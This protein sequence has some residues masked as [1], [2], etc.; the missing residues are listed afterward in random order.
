MNTY[1]TARN[2]AAKEQQTLTRID[3]VYEL[4]Q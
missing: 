1:R 3:Y 4:L 2:N